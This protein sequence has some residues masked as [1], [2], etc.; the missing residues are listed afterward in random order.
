MHRV[1]EYSFSNSMKRHSRIKKFTQRSKNVLRLFS[2]SIVNVSKTV[3]GVTLQY[4]AK[5]E[6]I[7]NQAI[8]KV[9]PSI[10]YK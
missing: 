7:G 10:I 1:I 8:I 3:I 9:P 4:W 6:L 2:S 5:T